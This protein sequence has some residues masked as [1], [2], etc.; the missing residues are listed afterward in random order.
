[1]TL[2]PHEYRLGRLLMVAFLLVFLHRVVTTQVATR[3]AG[4]LVL[5]LAIVAVYGWFWLRL[6]GTERV[7]PTV[8]ALVTLTL[9]VALYVL[10]VSPETYVFYY[11]AMVAG[12]AFRWDRGLILVAAVTAAAFA[13]ALPQRAGVAGAT[14]MA[15]VMVLLGTSAMAV[16][17]HLATTRDQE[18]A[19]D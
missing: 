2:A 16:R 13:V 3:G 7:R 10:T 19:T 1:M 18:A 17:S 9:L 14:H 12:A 6:A 5:V 15:I 11:P 4:P 8:I